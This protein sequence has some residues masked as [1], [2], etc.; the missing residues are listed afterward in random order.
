M[1]IQSCEQVS[2]DD[3][4]KKNQYLRLF[5][6]I[7]TIGINSTIYTSIPFLFYQSSLECYDKEKGFK[8]QCTTNEACDV[9][10]YV[11]S[12]QQTYPQIFS[13]TDELSLICDRSVFEAYVL[14][15]GTVGRVF[16][17]IA[18]IFYPVQKENKELF[19]NL[20]TL[21]IGITLCS[22]Q[23]F[24]S[25]GMLIISF[26][27]WY[28]CTC[29]VNGIIFIYMQEL[30]P[31][32]YA[33]YSVSFTS[34]GWFLGIFSYIIFVYFFGHWKNTLVH[35]IGL[36]CIIISSF[37]LLL[38]L[39]YPINQNSEYQAYSQ[40]QN[41]D[42]T[43]LSIQQQ[44]SQVNDYLSDNSRLN[45]QRIIDEQE[46]NIIEQQPYFEPKLQNSNQEN[47]LDIQQKDINLQSIEQLSDEKE[48]LIN[49]QIDQDTVFTEQL[50][51]QKTNFNESQLHIVNDNKIQKYLPFM[52]YKELR[53]NFYVWTFCY[54]C[55]GVNNACCYYFLNQIQ[56]DIYLKS[57]FSAIFEAFASF[58]ATFLVM[59]F[60]DSLKIVTTFI[61]LLTGLAFLACIFSYNPE[62]KM[63]LNQK[64]DYFNILLALL[65][66][67]IAKINF[68]I[69]WIILI[70]YQRQ[71][72][73]LRFQQQQFS[74][75]NL[76]NAF[77]ISCI[78]FYR[79]ICLNY[80]QNPFT[81]L[82]ILSL[83]ASATTYFLQE[84]KQDNY[85]EF[86][87]YVQTQ[88]NLAEE[89]ENDNDNS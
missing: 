89:R 78:P 47:L 35:F 59:A 29:L 55:I 7:L 74:T 11:I 41:E 23:W 17:N 14:T 75:T 9:G 83:L 84:I 70:T 46:D 71:L 56:G 27:T 16:A 63:Q 88:S 36:P 69:G 53:T 13:I 82:G 42:I 4:S 6:I 19:M 80:N 2:N 48:S 86:Q 85:A 54:V 67:I 73:P 60:K 22:L 50:L 52:L 26:F 32:N 66:I 61:F 87:I 30:L 51:Q 43:N 40:L 28:F 5:L 38:L 76:I 18:L 34:F 3:N 1:N 64:E 44:C 57:L 24:Y 77:S 37:N 58:V 25:L 12:N 62:N 8:Y 21:L 72:I 31:E 81:G 39:L 79:Y 45:T 68:D 15:S 65:P 20:I 33:N 10:S 49:K